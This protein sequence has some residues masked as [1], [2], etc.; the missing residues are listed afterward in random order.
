MGA[1]LLRLGFSLGRNHARARANMRVPTA[2][3]IQAKIDFRVRFVP[4]DG[5]MAA[6]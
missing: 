6:N 1:I 5:T 3:A 4:A 2:P